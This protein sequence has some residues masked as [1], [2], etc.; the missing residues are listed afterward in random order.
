[1]AQTFT[2]LNFKETGALKSA[3]NSDC[4]HV[5]KNIYAQLASNLADDRTPPPPHPS[6]VE[7]VLRLEYF[8]NL[9]SIGRDVEL[10][11]SHNHI[12][13]LTWQLNKLY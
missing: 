13:G 7:P 8:T 1:M 10:K 3:E 12:R 4:F 5:K 2:A 9:T 6:K 11:F